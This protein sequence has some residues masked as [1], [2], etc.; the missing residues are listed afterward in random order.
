M[1]GRMSSEPDAFKELGRGEGPVSRFPSLIDP[2]DLG[3][4]DMI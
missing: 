2:L 3:F 4:H 1:L